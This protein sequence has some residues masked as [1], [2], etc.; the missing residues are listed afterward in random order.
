MLCFAAP[1]LFPALAQSAGLAPWT[2]G[3][4][5]AQVRSFADYGPYRSFSNGDLETY[6]RMYDGQKENV[7]F[8]FDNDKLR[9]IGV[10]LYEGTDPE[11][12]RE[13]WKQAYESL[14]QKYGKIEMPGI[15]IKPG[16]DPADSEA[17]SVAAASA[18]MFSEEV[19]IAPVSQPTDM[20]VFSS[21]F[22]RDIQ[23]ARYYWV[24][25][26]LDSRH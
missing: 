11:V 14:A 16:T 23:G 5:K 10:Y 12:A 24:V 21:F 22:R 26:N 15:V 4:S 25:I 13:A 19:Q 7:Q 17:I 2:F 9:R 18:L 20:F 1:L 3:M 6:S 8:F